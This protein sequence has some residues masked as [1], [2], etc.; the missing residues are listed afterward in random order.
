[1]GQGGHD[2]HV[3]HSVYGLQ[4]CLLCSSVKCVIIRNGY[5]SLRIAKVEQELASGR[6][7]QLSDKYILLVCQYCYSSC[8]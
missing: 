7:Q 1:M 2:T 3:K 5:L 4:C 6:C 8:V